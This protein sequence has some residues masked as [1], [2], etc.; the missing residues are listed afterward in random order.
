MA[1][2]KLSPDLEL[3]YGRELTKTLKRIDNLTEELKELNAERKG[4]IASLKKAA[5]R[6]RLLLEGQ[7]AE[8]LEVPGSEVPSVRRSGRPGA[9]GDGSEEEEE[10]GERG[11]R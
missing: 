1:K 10:P 11:R 6:L 3:K 2:S 8:Q 7:D 4:E 5:Y 9:F